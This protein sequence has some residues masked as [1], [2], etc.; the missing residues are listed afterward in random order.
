MELRV[1]Q[2]EIE[3]LLGADRGKWSDEVFERYDT[4]IQREA[5]LLRDRPCLDLTS[6]GVGRRAVPLRRGGPAS[7]P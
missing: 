6:S 2:E 4:L 7:S 3:A 1:V 5:A